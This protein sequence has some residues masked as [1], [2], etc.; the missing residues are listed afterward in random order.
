MNTILWECSFANQLSNIS[1]AYIANVHHNRWHIPVQSNWFPYG[2]CR[3]ISAENTAFAKT[4]VPVECVMQMPGSNVMYTN[5]CQ[6]LWHSLHN[7][8]WDRSLL[9]GP[10]NGGLSLL[11]CLHDP[12]ISYRTEESILEIQMA[13]M[14]LE[15]IYS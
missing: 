14:R 8:Y 6:R 9:S 7:I 15:S 13:L 10:F 3:T 2:I 1:T 11:M 4:M 5:D 12:A